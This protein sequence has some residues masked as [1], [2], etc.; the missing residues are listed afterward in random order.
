MRKRSTTVTE[1]IPGSRLL[2]SVDEAASL[3]CLGR[4]MV[5]SLVL[6]GEIPSIK[7]GRIRRIPMIGLQ[8]YITRAGSVNL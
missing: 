7:V 2:V 5:Y 1:V 3:L 4:T 8:A 6:R